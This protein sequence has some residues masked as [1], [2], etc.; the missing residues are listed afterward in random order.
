MT[1]ARL[2]VDLLAELPNAD[3]T[4]RPFVLL[5]ADGGELGTGRYVANVPRASIIQL[6][7]NAAD[8][9]ERG[10]EPQERNR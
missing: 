2:L 6:L 1:T 3:G 8:R 7:R 4:A 10:L 9:L 5:V